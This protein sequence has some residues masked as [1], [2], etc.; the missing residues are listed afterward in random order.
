MFFYSIGK[1]FPTDTY[2]F[3]ALDSKSS[4][5]K[6]RGGSSPPSGTCKNPTGKG[7]KTFPVGFLLLR[8]VLAE[9][10]P[11]SVSAITF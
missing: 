4:E 5:G 1:S 2:D 3:L 10:Q 9:A 11:M 8:L 6:P 7:M